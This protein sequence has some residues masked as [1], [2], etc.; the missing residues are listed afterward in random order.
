MGKS[1]A[2]PSLH[3]CAGVRCTV[4]RLSGNGNPLL[5]MAAL[6][7]SRLSRMEASGSPTVVKVGNPLA[8][9]TSTSISQASTPSKVLFNTLAGTAGPC[10]IVCSGRQ[11]FLLPL[12]EFL[13][14]VHCP[15]QVRWGLQ[16]FEIL[17]CCALLQAF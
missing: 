17:Q 2:V 5:A 10:H 11:V 13:S 1:N 3:T 16:F 12:D 4:M 6:T 15:Q 14:A 7:R 8:R 9:S